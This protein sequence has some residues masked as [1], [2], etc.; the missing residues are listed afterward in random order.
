MIE[1]IYCFTLFSTVVPSNIRMFLSCR[2]FV[3]I[4]TFSPGL[5]KLDKLDGT[6]VESKT[7]N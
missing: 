5:V 4:T 6:T 3:V 7:I 1:L 2:T